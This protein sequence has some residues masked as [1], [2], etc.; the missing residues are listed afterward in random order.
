M[1]SRACLRTNVPRSDAL[2]LL[3]ELLLPRLA[4]QFHRATLPVMIILMSFFV[5]FTVALFS[6]HITAAARNATTNEVRLFVL[7]KQTR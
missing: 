3:T 2:Y 4:A 7:P 1:R 6:V 5:V